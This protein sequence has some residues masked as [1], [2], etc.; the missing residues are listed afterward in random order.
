MGKLWYLKKELSVFHEN[1][2][3]FGPPNVQNWVKLKNG[4]ILE[5]RSKLTKLKALYF[6]ELLK[7][8]FFIFALFFEIL[9]Y[10]CFTPILTFG[11]PK[12]QQFSWK[13]DNSFFKYHNF[14]IQFSTF[15]TMENYQFCIRGSELAMKTVANLRYFWSNF[16]CAAAPML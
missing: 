7:F 1:C 16:C 2:C 4:H 6:L 10:F 15:T 5:N 14:P 12:P 8:S 3:G 11:G 9:P 13:T